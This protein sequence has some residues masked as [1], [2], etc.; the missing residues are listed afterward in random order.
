[1]H[2]SIA[3]NE[4][5]NLTAA[6]ENRNLTVKTGNGNK[7]TII[8]KKNSEQEKDK[9][10]NKEQRKGKISCHIGG[11]HNAAPINGWEM[12]KSIKICLN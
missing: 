12:L 10:Q 9:K 5:L 6:K 4:I 1:M 11:Q 2:T 3:I 7:H 8:G